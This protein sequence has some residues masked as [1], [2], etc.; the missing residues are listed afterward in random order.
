MDQKTRNLRRNAIDN[1]RK[2]GDAPETNPWFPATP[3]Q[4]KMN[5]GNTNVANTQKGNGAAPKGNGCF[6]CGAP[7]HFKRD[8]P[9]LR[10]KDGGNGNVQG[11]VYAVGNAEKRGN[12]PG[13]PDA[14]VVTGRRRFNSVREYTKKDWNTCDGKHYVYMAVELDTYAMERLKIRDYERITQVEI[15]LSSMVLKRCTKM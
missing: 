8:Y 3:S 15:F 9:K 12:A 10:N 7:R 11:W 5:T 4:S 1:K 14:N 2:A 13:N 6:E